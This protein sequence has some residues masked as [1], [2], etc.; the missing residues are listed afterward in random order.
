M[1]AYSAP[2]PIPQPARGADIMVHP[3]SIPGSSR[4][5]AAL[6]L[7]VATSLLTAATI[8][9]LAKSPAVPETG[10]V[11][12]AGGVDGAGGASSSAEFYNVKRHKFFA[13]GSMASP[14][15]GLQAQWFPATSVNRPTNLGVVI[16]GFSGTAAPSGISLDFD[17]SALAT[18]E[19][20]DPSDGSFSPASGPMAQ[21]RAFA[22]SIVFPGDVSSAP[23]LDSH[24]LVWG[25]LCDSTSLA[26]C[27]TASIIHSD[28]LDVTATSNPKVAA[29]FDQ[30]TLLKDD[31][32][33][34]T[35]GFGDLS[36]GTLNDGQVFNPSDESI[37][38]PAATMSSGR[39]GH[40][41]TLL[42]DGTVLIVGGVANSGGTLNALDSAE[43]YDPASQT[44]TAL[45]STLN[46]PR[47]FHSATLLGD[48][49][50][51]IAGG[52]DGD[53]ALAMTGSASGVRGSLS[54]GS[55]RILNTAEIYDPASRSFRCVKGVVKKTGLCKPSMKA[56]R[57]GHTATA[58]NDGDVLL[59]GGFGPSSGSFI[60]LDSAERFHGKGFKK[61]G[62]MTHPRALHAAMVVLP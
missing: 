10:D 43:I 60:A 17:V 40:T 14:R 21:G 32:V 56:A 54:I 55:G 5:R 42:N 27:R 19:A 47:A 37:T 16:G 41:A 61:V 46:Q 45:S 33:L 18:V 15:A 49:S 52:I 50:V 29:M 35:G 11:V 57:F 44:F 30:L 9:A 6:A 58:L 20:Y 3:P 7:T 4:L 48:G 8:P 36:G 2:E 51:L 25:G 38:Q 24:V 23:F 28:D 59:A 13:T 22:S 53:G 1:I 39:A 62:R 34:E 12:I 26:N 31:S